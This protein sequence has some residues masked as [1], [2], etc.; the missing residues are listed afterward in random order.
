MTNFVE[1]L[2]VGAID[3]S[4]KCAFVEEEVLIFLE[5]CISNVEEFFPKARWRIV[6]KVYE[7]EVVRSVRRMPT[8][9]QLPCDPSL[10]P[11]TCRTR[12]KITEI[13]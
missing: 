6:S 7:F 2:A 1:R 8:G 4:S 10:L 13:D 9:S 12:L 11:A 5:S 3:E